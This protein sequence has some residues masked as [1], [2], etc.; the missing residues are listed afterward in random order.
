MARPV[1]LPP[2]FTSPLAAQLAQ[3]AEKFAADSGIPQ[4]ER[5]WQLMTDALGHHLPAA[6]TRTKAA[7][8]RIRRLR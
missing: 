8:A 5:S 1:V 7:T 4:V 2:A 6:I 3:D